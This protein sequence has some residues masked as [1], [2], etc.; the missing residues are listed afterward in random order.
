MASLTS[1]AAVALIALGMVLTPGPN[2]LY[3]ISRSVTQGRGAGMVSLAGVATGFLVYL[4][5][6]AAGIAVVFAVV[7]AVYTAVKLA[8]AAYLLW[9]AWKALRPGNDV[10]APGETRF[11][12]PRRLFSMGLLT[13]LLNPKIAVMYVSLLPQFVDP[14]LGNVAAQGLALGLVQV[15]VSLSVNTLIVLAAGSVAAFLARRPM[16]ARVQRYL[17]A[18]VLAG[19]AVRVATDRSRALAAVP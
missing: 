14:A 1:F 11:D 4:A 8:G 10:F 17:T 15:V 18:T 5:A 12:P 19:I 6:T 2:M 7:P 13:S 16:W 3:L 9:M